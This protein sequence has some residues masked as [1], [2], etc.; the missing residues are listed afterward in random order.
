MQLRP[1]QQKAINDTRTA[2][3]QG[4]KAVLLEMATGAGKTAVMAHA[5]DGVSRKGRRSAIIA[6]RQELI[7]QTSM[8]LAKQGIYHGMI[9][10]DSVVRETIKAQISELGRS[11]F[12]NDA[13]VNCSSVQTMIRR[14]YQPFQFLFFDEAHHVTE[15]NTW[16]KVMQTNAGAHAL[17][18]T[19]TAERLDG[20]GLG[21][22]KG[23]YFDTIV[24]G[25]DTPELMMDGYLTTA[26]VWGPQQ[27]ID[28]SEIQQDAAEHRR[29]DFN[30]D[31]AAAVVDKPSIT[32]DAIAHYSRI[33]PFQP[34]IVF[35]INVEHAKNVAEDFKAAGYRFMCIDGSMS[36]GERR[37]AIRALA[38]GRLHG[39]TSCEIIN[40]GTDI[41]VVAAAI[42]LRPTQSLGL[43]KQ[44]VGRVLRPVYSRGA[45]LGSLQGRLDAIARS[46]K[47]RAIILDHVG[48]TLR[49][50][51]PDDPYRGSLEGRTKRSRA[52]SDSEMPH[53]TARQC[54]KCYAI[55]KGTL[56]CCP[57]CGAP[58]ELT[59]REIEHREGELVRIQRDEAERRKRE[60]YWQQRN[61]QENAKTLED[62]VK[63]FVSQGSDLP[64]AR[65]RAKYI[66]A[67]RESK[68]TGDSKSIPQLIGG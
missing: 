11:F 17:G 45:D 27:Q 46:N 41:P 21:R 42:L 61:A 18:V 2:Y 14:E 43:H 58:A 49:H 20:K 33:C 1:Y 19:A 66:L 38:E 59:R 39:L 6:H 22:G 13:P 34:A 15:G 55:Y 35:C 24:Y 28:F 9:A 16:G 54:G 8:T 4:A 52:A 60:E 53:V 29:K 40:E 67:A 30:L 44:Q 5:A 57:A 36:D 64:K 3:G 48:N 65:A 10:P 56:R 25:P 63:L 26:E 7:L 68:K 12:N 50:G 32:G 51:L 31:I 62:L 47:P 37:A 23:G